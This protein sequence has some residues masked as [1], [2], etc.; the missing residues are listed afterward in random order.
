VYREDLAHYPDNGWSLAGLAAAQRAQGDGA[1]AAA[2][3]ARFQA[4]WAKADI[5]L[6]GSRF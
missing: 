5:A 4:A 1:A 6:P 2:T 3:Q